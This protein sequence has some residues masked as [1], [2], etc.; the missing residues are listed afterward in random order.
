M[1][2]KKRKTCEFC[3][4]EINVTDENTPKVCGCEHRSLN[5]WFALGTK[6]V[7]DKL[8]KLGYVPYLNSVRDSGYELG[9][10]SIRD[11]M[12]YNGINFR[13]EYRLLKYEDGNF[14]EDYT[15]K[16]DGV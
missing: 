8:V 13:P 7:F 15:F 12:I 5:G 14:T 11:G 4:R 3:D 6:Q 10:Y 2:F 16:K 1:A 9:F